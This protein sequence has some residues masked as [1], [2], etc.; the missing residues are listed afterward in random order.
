MDLESILRAGTSTGTRMTHGRLD[1]LDDEGRVL[2]RADGA[3]GAVPVV[4]GLEVSDGAL[5]KAARVGRRALVLADEEN[6][7]PGVLVAL[8]RERVA[9]KAR[10]AVPGELEVRMDGETLVLR[11]EQEIELRCGKSRLK[12]RADGRVMLNGAHIVSA[13]SG[14]HRIK[15]ATIALN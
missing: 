9:A 5:V 7:G 14:P 11:A 2:F 4:I 8:I 10:D 1:G 3:N 15:G 12:L 6:R 13:S